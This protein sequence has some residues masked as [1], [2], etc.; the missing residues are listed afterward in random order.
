[1]G[2]ERT[3]RGSICRGSGYR[4]TV[5][6]AGQDRAGTAG[7]WSSPLCLHQFTLGWAGLHSPPACTV[8]GDGCGD[9]W[10]EVHHR[11]PAGGGSGSLLCHLLV[12]HAMVQ[13]LCDMMAL[14]GR[15]IACGRVGHP[16]F[17]IRIQRHIL[18]LEVQG[19]PTHRWLMSAIQALTQPPGRSWLP[20][21]RGPPQ[22]LLLLPLCFFGGT[23]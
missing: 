19:P 21:K 18:Q 23:D 9:S 8:V 13:W 17:G 22:R 4:G 5:G 10:K 12:L 1:M 16:A 6:R 7:L 2:R 14:G 3:G 15:A 20:L 11:D